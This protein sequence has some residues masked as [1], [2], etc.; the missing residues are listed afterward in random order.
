MEIELLEH[1][2]TNVGAEMMLA[3]NID[4]LRDLQCLR[5]SIKNIKCKMFFID[6]D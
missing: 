5:N 1:T 6:T 4:S 3:I 2:G